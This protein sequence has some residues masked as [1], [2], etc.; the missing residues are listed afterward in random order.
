MLVFKLKDAL[1]FEK[2]GDSSICLIKRLAIGREC[3][4]R[5][6]NNGGSLMKSCLRLNIL[7]VVAFQQQRFHHGIRIEQ[8]CRCIGSFAKP[9]RFV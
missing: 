5:Y 1:L 3:G 9:A 4:S 8:H 7:V 2:N 6:R